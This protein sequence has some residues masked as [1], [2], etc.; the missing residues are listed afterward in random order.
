M[1]ESTMIQSFRIDCLTEARLRI[2]CIPY[3]ERVNNSIGGS[4]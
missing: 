2:L 1:A 3:H 4:W